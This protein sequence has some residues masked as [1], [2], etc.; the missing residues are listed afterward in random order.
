MAE[1]GTSHRKPE[2]IDRMSDSVTVVSYLQPS[3]ALMYGCLLSR[4]RADSNIILLYF[5][6]LL[7]KQPK[8]SK[9]SFRLRERKKPKVTYGM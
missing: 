4:N 6:F 3:L 2:P 8:L 5:K 7:V 9:R 1:A